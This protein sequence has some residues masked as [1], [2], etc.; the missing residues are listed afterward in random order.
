M[1]FNIVIYMAKRT[2]RKKEEKI[3]GKIYQSNLLCTNYNGF[4]FNNLNKKDL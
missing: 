3:K 1:L 2:Q 4:L